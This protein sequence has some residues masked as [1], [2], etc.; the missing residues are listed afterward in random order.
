MAG[1]MIRVISAHA[2]RD[3]EKTYGLRT[4]TGKQF[5]FWKRQIRKREEPKYQYD[6]DN[7]WS[8]QH[9]FYFFFALLGNG[10]DTMPHTMRFALKTSGGLFVVYDFFFSLL[11]TF[12]LLY[13]EMFLGKY[14]NLTN[15]QMFRMMPISFGVCVLTLLQDMLYASMSSP[16]I[17][18][19][20]MATFDHLLKSTWTCP[21]GD[22]ICYD[23]KV[24]G[25]LGPNCTRINMVLDCNGKKRLIV[26]MHHYWSNYQDRHDFQANWSLI[27]VTLITWM[28]ITII[29]NLKMKFLELVKNIALF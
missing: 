29:V 15:S 13:T 12:P 21:P 6:V 26:S 14:S 2:S 18:M 10:F 3:L 24:E 19:S 20:L 5:T 22:P 25:P 17:A 8:Q 28:F 9:C 11:I 23:Y 16:S 7:Q 4:D 27:L 1:R